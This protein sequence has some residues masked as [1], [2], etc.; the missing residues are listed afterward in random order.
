M[1]MDSR[2]YSRQTS[3]GWASTPTPSDVLAALDDLG[4]QVVR[5]TEQEAWSICPGHYSRVGRENVRPDKWSVNIETGQHSCFSCGFSGSFVYLV[6]EV[7]GYD[8]HDAEQWVRGRG[9]VSRLRRI[10][11]DSQGRS[12]HL[13][14]DSRVQPWNEARLAFFSDPPD[15]ARLGRRVSEGALEHYGVLWDSEKENWILPIRSPYTGELWGYQEKGEGWFSN[16]P[17]RV[18]KSETLFGLD[19]F[20]G[21]TAIL[22]ESPLDCLRLYSASV[23]GGLSSFGVQTSDTQLE[24]LFDTAEEIIFALD[25]DEAGITK[26]WDLRNRYLRSGRKIKFADYSHISW[27]KDLG[28]EGVSDEDIQKAIQNAKSLIRYRPCLPEN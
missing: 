27:A 4:I 1:K 5:L 12:A 23:F 19:C 21:T 16:K 15:S 13:Q 18:K 3:S 22:L 7:K 14:G 28:T 6:Q 11:A 10:L 2:R 25:N 9:G 24:L 26:S 20:E 8:R 17:A